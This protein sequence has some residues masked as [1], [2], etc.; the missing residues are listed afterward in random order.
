MP[1]A[2]RFKMQEGAEDLA[3]K[4]AHEDD[5]AWDLKSRID[6]EAQPGKVTL[7]PTGLSWSFRQATKRRY[8]RA[9]DLRSKTPSPC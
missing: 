7:V 4:K 3:P 6:A 8:A 9:A 5:A 2:I 1:L